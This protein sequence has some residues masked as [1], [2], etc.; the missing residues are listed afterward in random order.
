MDTQKV[1]KPFMKVG[2]SDVFRFPFS[3]QFKYIYEIRGC[4]TFLI[5]YIGHFNEGYYER[6]SQT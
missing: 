2:L 1:R 4:G 3:S 6:V 5:F